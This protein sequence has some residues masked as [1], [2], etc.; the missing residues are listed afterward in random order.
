MTVAT[1]KRLEEWFDRGV[2]VGAAFM[3]VVCDTYDHSDFPV[4]KHTAEGA[5]A[6]YESY[7]A[8]SM[9]RVMEVYNLRE[10]RDEQTS[11]RTRVFRLPE[12]GAAP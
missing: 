10:D 6:S 12:I 8:R 9:Y 11:S 2:E 3:I 7:R 5:W 1:R 4:F